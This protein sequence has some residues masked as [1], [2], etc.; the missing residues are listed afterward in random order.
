MI[1]NILLGGIMSLA[2]LSVPVVADAETK[3][4]IMEFSEPEMQAITVTVDGN[5]LHVSGAAGETLRIYNVAGVCVMT[6]KLE[7]ESKSIELDLQR[8]C[9][10]IKVGKTVRKISLK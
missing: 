5:V 6:V 8:G 7:S 4:D 1:K 10:I 3:I 2:L 9:Y